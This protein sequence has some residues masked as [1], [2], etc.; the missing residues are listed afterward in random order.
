[1]SL[2][3]FFIW[4]VAFS[5][6]VVGTLSGAIDH[7]SHKK[8]TTKENSLL[9]VP[10][11]SGMLRISWILKNNNLIQEPWHFKLLSSIN[12]ANNRLRAGEFEIQAGASLRDILSALTVGKL[13]K[14][15]LI[16]P[17]GTSNAQIADI[18]EAAPGLKRPDILPEEGYLLP[19]TYFYHYGSE[20]TVLI[21][22]MS[23]QLTNTLDTLWNERSPDFPLKSKHELL[24]LASI[25]EKETGVASE[26][27]R[28]AGVFLNRLKRGMRLESDPTVIYGITNGLPLERR[29]RKSDL[30]RVTEY[31]TYKIKGLPRG[32]IANAGL[33]SIEAVLNAA[34]GEDLFFVADG[35]GGHAFSKTLRQ[36]NKNVRKWRKIRDA[37]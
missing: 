15:R 25:V 29:L 19:E 27:K 17:E 11:G 23:Q 21:E 7:F 4:V 6:I 14:R 32:P 5:C 10:P 2:S 9:Y 22:Q 37:L 35:S 12:G 13:H 36:H 1:M 31:N 34:P 30:K 8:S 20:T 26:R 18:F 16:I 24:T 28:V 3:R 33:A